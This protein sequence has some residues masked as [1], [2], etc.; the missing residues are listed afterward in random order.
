MR[1]KLYALA[2]SVALVLMAG[3]LGNGGTYWP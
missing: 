2:S 3:F 1:N